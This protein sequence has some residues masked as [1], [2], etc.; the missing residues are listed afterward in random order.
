MTTGTPRGFNLANMPPLS[1][2][3]TMNGPGGFPGFPNFG[4]H[5]V[6]MPP[7]WT[8]GGAPS[9]VD[10]TG[11]HQ[12]GPMRRGGGRFQNPR[13][14]PYDRR[15]PRFSNTGRLSPPRGVPAIPGMMMGTRPPTGKWDGAGMQGSIGPQEATQGRALKSYQDLDAVGGVGSGELNY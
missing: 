4:N 9:M 11:M 1:G 2:F 5:A 13:Q 15:Q 14:G 7:G 3:G 6:Q 8:G 12:P 10:P